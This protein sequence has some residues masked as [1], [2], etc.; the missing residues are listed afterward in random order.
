MNFPL[1][2]R[3]C[4]ARCTQCKERALESEMTV[5]MQR[6]HF[7][8]NGVSTATEV[9]SHENPGRIAAAF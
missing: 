4:C 8:L 2:Q 9:G 3:R 7:T 6:I 5:P 1:R